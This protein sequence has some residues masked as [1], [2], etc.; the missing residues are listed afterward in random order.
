MNNLIHINFKDPI[1]E[2]YEGYQDK[3][4]GLKTL[5]FKYFGADANKA[6]N[7]LGLE[8]SATVSLQ[9]LA[10]TIQAA[11]ACRYYQPELI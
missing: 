4:A 3:E 1:V 2:E 7:Y 10:M 5:A 8:G 11:A 9:E 6:S